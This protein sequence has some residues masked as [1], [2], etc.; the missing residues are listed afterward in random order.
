MKT[1]TVS[2]SAKGMRE[3]KREL[4][5]YKTDLNKKIAI[6][7]ERLADLGISVA[8]ANGGEFGNQIIFT[9]EVEIDGQR[10]IIAYVVGRDKFPIL[11]EW[12][13]HG[14]IKQ[15]EVSPL[16]MA[17]FGSGWYSEPK[18]DNAN[19]GQGTFP[20]Q[21][22]AFN[23]D[24]WTWTTPDGETHH[25]YGERPTYPMYNAYTE[26]YM[27]AKRIFQEVFR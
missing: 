10:R 27:Q 14:N 13:Y 25:S 17:E 19:G 6:C 1:I 11:R 26:M 4:E 16:Y 9:K 22:H 18:F 12:F 15:V 8:K 23:E 24:G 2:A 21:K 7:I 20:N 5:K 3:L